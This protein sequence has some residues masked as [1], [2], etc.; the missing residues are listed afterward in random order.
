[1]RVRIWEGQRPRAWILASSSGLIPR[2][3]A[4][5]SSSLSSSSGLRVLG[6][7]AE[8]GQT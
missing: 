7:S 4:S 3:M 8:Q 1:M 5:S 2:E 6:T